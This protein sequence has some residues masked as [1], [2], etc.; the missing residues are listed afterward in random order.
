MKAAYLLGLLFLWS[1]YGIFHLVSAAI[2][3]S[4]S[5]DAVAVNP[6]SP[7]AHECLGSDTSS[8]ILEFLAANSPQRRF[9][10]QGWRWHT[11]SLIREATLLSRAAAVEASDPQSLFKATEYV[12][13]FNMKGLHRVENEVFFPWMKEKLS[14]VGSNGVR[15][16][17]LITFDEVKI[18]Q[19][20]A[21]ELGK[22]MV[23]SRNACIGIALSSIHTTYPLLFLF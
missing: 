9:R 4:D 2:V 19:K 6:Q 23:R 13:D 18:D 12:I 1:Q 16:A 7:I 3:A 10:I 8:K 11:M 14:G 20:K 22:S 21:S 17:L 15:E 5:D